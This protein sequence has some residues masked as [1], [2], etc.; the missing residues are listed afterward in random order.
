MV[1]KQLIKLKYL[2]NYYHKKNLL[3]EELIYLNLLMMIVITNKKIFLK[4]ILCKI[5][6]NGNKHINHEYYFN[7]IIFNIKKNAKQKSKDNVLKILK[8]LRN[9]F[10]YSR[11][12]KCLIECY[13]INYTIKRKNWSYLDYY[14]KYNCLEIR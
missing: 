5:V 7:I 10:I 4:L 1:S 11:L 14:L 12:I 2:I 6:L 13:I 9:S 8:L 3:I